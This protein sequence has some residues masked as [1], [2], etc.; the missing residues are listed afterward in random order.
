MSE[1]EKRDNSLEGLQK[2][3]TENKK[4]TNIVGIAV[5]G[6]V[7]LFFAYKFLYQVPREKEGLA[8]IRN[9]QL[10]FSRDS[11]DQV[12]EGDLDYGGAEDLASEYSG[13]KAGKLAAYY[14][15]IA[16]LKQGKYEEAIPL[17]KKFSPSDRMMAALAKGSLGDAYAGTGDTEK[18]ASAY[19]KG[20]NIAA[21]NDNPLAGIYLF[22]K[23]GAAYEKLGDFKKS[24]AAYEAIKKNFKEEEEARDIDKYI[25]KLKA[26]SG[27]FNQE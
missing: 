3:Y 12:L 14:A 20:A 23:A 5:L 22:K 2:W 8:S 25:Y 10:Q 19:M 13:T 7:G 1:S 11:F 26:R 4:I 15:G 24:L 18:A 27:E 16:Y 6:V 21:N 17:L 9:I